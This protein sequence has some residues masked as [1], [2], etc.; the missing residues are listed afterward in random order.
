MSLLKY[1]VLIYIDEPLHAW[2]YIKSAPDDA[3]LVAML[4]SNPP[5]G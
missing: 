3:T 1:D 4:T 5:N 2:T